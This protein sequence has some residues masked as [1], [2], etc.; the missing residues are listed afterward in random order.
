MS[1]AQRCAAAICWGV[2]LGNSAANSGRFGVRSVRCAS[3]AAGVKREGDSRSV[4]LAVARS[5]GS[6][7]S[8]AVGACAVRVSMIA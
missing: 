4:R 6:H 1:R 3:V 8:G 2:L 7:M 5:I